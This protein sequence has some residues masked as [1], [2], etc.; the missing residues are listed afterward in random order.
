MQRILTHLKYLKCRRFTT[1]PVWKYRQTVHTSKAVCRRKP[2]NEQEKTEAADFKIPFSYEAESSGVPWQ[3]F[4]WWAETSRIKNPS[5]NGHRGDVRLNWTMSVTPGHMFV[6]QNRVNTTFRRVVLMVCDW[7]LLDTQIQLGK[8]SARYFF[9]DVFF[10]QSIFYWLVWLRDKR[11]D[12]V[13]ITRISKK[14]DFIYINTQ[15]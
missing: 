3:L 10:C 2:R 15:K 13:V 9:V 12:G 11:T 1:W 7:R 4:V 5:I 8:L 14:M 6:Q